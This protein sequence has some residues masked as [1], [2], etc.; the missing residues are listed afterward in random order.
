MVKDGMLHVRRL[1]RD[2]LAIPFNGWTPPQSP[3]RAV[4]DFPLDGKIY[5]LDRSA[6]IPVEGP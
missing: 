1:G 3:I 6:L 5:R 4:Q 2:R